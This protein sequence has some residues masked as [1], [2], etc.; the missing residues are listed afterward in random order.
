MQQVARNATMED[1]GYLKS[2]RHVLHDRDKKFCAEFRDTLAAG[3][4]SCVALP[5]RNPNLN[6]ESSLRR[7]LKKL[8]EHYHAERNHQGKDN[9]LLFPRAG[10]LGSPGRGMVRCQER[11]GGLLKY[12][13]REAE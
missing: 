8:C 6:W 5:A 7:A 1:T 9:A 11:L 10:P 3:G 2:C 13:Y 12:Y 4:V